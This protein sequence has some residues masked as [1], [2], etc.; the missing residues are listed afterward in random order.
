MLN[1]INYA[2]DVCARL[3]LNIYD[4]RRRDFSILSDPSCLVHVF[5]V[6]LDIGDIRKPHRRAVSVGNDDGSILCA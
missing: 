6:V 4:D 2:D 3:P 5:N 1:P